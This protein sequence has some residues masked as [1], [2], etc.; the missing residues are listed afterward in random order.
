M[1]KATLLMILLMIPLVSAEIK[2]DYYHYKINQSECNLILESIPEKYYEGIKKIRVWGIQPREERVYDGL[3]F[4]S[5]IIHIYDGCRNPD[6]L[7]H[8]LTHQD[9]KSIKHD[10]FFWLSY[11]R[12][13]Y[14]N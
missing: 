1:K 13:K 12:I 3:W 11:Y 6:T 14:E 4:S 5:G 8:E 9:T 10:S 2:V 7:I